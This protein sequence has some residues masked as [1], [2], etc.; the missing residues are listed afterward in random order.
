MS[1]NFFAHS[2]VKFTCVN[3]IEAMYER[4]RVN[5]KTAP[6]S[7]FMFTRDTSY[8][9]SILYTRVKYTCLRT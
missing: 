3:K 7:T 6:R 2:R 1:R 8:V 4:S 5:V 9:A